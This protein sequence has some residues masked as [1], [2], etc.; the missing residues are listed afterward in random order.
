MM[1]V[2]TMGSSP[3]PTCT[4]KMAGRTGS[5][6]SSGRPPRKPPPT[7]SPTART[8]LVPSRSDSRM[9]ADRTDDSSALDPPALTHPSM[10]PPMR[11]GWSL[12]PSSSFGSP[13]AKTCTASQPGIT[14]LAKLPT[15]DRMSGHQGAMLALVSNVNTLDRMGWSSPTR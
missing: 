9:L 5:S 11:Y 3:A 13:K 15:P 6:C 14:P 4:G 7:P 1:C 10:A 8:A 2:E 12:Q